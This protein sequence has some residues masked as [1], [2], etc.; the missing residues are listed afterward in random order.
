M[1]FQV[2]DGPFHGQYASL[3]YSFIHLH[4]FLGPPC[5]I[6]FLKFKPFCNLFSRNH[7]SYPQGTDFCNHSWTTKLNHNGHDLILVTTTFFGDISPFYWKNPF[8]KVYVF[9][10]MVWSLCSYIRNFWDLH[11]E[12]DSCHVL[13]E[14]QLCPDYYLVSFFQPVKV[15]VFVFLLFLQK[16]N[17][18]K[19]CKAVVLA[20]W[21]FL[22]PSLLALIIWFPFYPFPL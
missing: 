7:C 22:N 4:H 15:L 10:G 5:L 20:R 14:Y 2:V 21:F 16:Y 9:F 1:K 6:S 13:R 3:S 17:L 19:T 18:L 12:I 11:L 8:L